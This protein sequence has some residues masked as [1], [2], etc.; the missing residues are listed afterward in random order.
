MNN[1]QHK[2]LLEDH[3][4]LLFRNSKISYTKLLLTKWINLVG[5]QSSSFTKEI[6]SDEYLKFL[7]KLF[8]I[9]YYSFTLSKNEMLT[10]KDFKKQIQ[11]LS[12]KE[13]KPYISQEMH[14]FITVMLFIDKLLLTHTKNSFNKIIEQLE[15]LNFSPKTTINVIDGVEYEIQVKPSITI[16]NQWIIN[17]LLEFEN[18]NDIYKTKDL[19]KHNIPWTE[20]KILNILEQN[21]E[22]KNISTN[23]S[24]SNSIVLNSYLKEKYKSYL[25]LGT[26]LDNN[27][28]KALKKET[29]VKNV[30]RWLKDSVKFT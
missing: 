13:L 30:I 15:S 4:P 27:T 2:Y 18:T 25:E 17:K 26:F 5:V 24:S 20:D 8:E 14:Q 23:E 22:L 21:G 12:Y 28:S 6:N 11:S 9:L 10:I 7:T 19:K 1:H 29:D 16:N 3:I